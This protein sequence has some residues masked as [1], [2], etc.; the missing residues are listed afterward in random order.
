MMDGDLSGWWSRRR[1]SRRTLIAAGGA[2]LAAT[3]LACSSK[4]TGTSS[5][6]SGQQ[7][8]QGTSG[9]PQT[10]G[11]L[12]VTQ[13]FNPMLDPQKQSSVQYQGAGGVMQRLLRFQ[14]GADPN[15]GLSHI[16]EPDLATSVE[17]PDAITWTIK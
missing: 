6:T 1:L 9:P 13:N 17:S 7:A 12:T 11:T 2:G 8:A 10:G 3:A 15:T 14:T 16:V 4:R 5:G